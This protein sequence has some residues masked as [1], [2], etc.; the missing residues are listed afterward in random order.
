MEY[1]ISLFVDGYSPHHDG[2]LFVTSSDSLIGSCLVSLGVTWSCL[3][4]PDYS[5][6][7]R[8]S[9]IQGCWELAHLSFCSGRNSQSAIGRQSSRSPSSFLFKHH[10][11]LCCGPPVVALCYLDTPF[12]SQKSSKSQ[13]RSRQSNSIPTFF[14]CVSAS[15]CRLVLWSITWGI[16]DLVCRVSILF[17]NHTTRSMAA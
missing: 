13:S 7:T 14:Q 6:F 3:L 2:D 16:S 9:V 1:R 12:V 17:N 4:L 10:L 8:P 11:V 5:L 15:N